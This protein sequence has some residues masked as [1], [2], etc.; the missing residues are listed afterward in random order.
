M[1]AP[2]KND[3]QTLDPGFV[4]EWSRRYLEVWNAHDGDAVAAFCTEYVVWSDPGLPEPITGRGGV[5]A[6][7]AATARAFP[8]FHVDELEPPFLSPAEPR[9][10]SP[11]RMTGTMLGDWEAAGLAATG[12]RIDVI[13]VDD[14]TFRDGLLS[15]YS[16]YYDSL[17]MARQL[18]ILPSVG[19][20]GDRVMARVQHAQARLQRRQQSRA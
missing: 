4:E 19:S 20:V 17:G 18:G 8:D 13:G 1:E 14:W 15:R 11:Y 12:A 9:V 7:V 2:V 6:F 16:T 10:L 3:S 5:R